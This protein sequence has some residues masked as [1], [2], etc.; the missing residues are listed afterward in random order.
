L[1]ERIYFLGVRSQRVRGAIESLWVSIHAQT[2][3]LTDQAILVSSALSVL[4][5]DIR[6]VLSIIELM[7]CDFSPLDPT[8]SGY[9]GMV[10]NTKNASLEVVATRLSPFL[11]QRGLRTVPD[12]G[13]LIEAATRRLEPIAL[14]RAAR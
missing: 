7:Q 6:D 5:N 3:N 1:A 11:R 4:N 13:S 10:G 14:A 8:V 12:R 2:W 9:F